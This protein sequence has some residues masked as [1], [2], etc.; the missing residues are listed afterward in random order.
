MSR[1]VPVQRLRGSD[2]VLLEVQIQDLLRR[3][4]AQLEP[5]N[6]LDLLA[7]A[8][9]PNAPASVRTEL[10]DYR[11]R[12]R[13]EISDIPAGRSWA[14]FVEEL[15]TLTAERVPE[16]FRTWMTEELERPDRTSPDLAEWLSAWAPVPPLP[17]EVGARG[18]KVTRARAE[19]PAPTVVQ[20]AR[21]QRP[22][23]AAP[24]PEPTDADRERRQAIRA[25]AIDRIDD[26]GENGLQE[27]VLTA[28]IRFRLRDRFPLLP[29]QEIQSVLAEIKASGRARWT[30]GR[31]L[32]RGR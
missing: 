17:F 19:P 25:V 28:G 2:P 32:R 18:A 21:A 24:R 30:A 12:S 9:L 16:T 26:S 6:A 22:T 20:K 14:E 10:D 11:R 1:R 5:L 4:F 8:E 15:R 29:P 27:A 23:A 31:Y 13:I 7:L 3:P